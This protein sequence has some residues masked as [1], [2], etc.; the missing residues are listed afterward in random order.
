MYAL[1][2]LAETKVNR[3]NDEPLR[4]RAWHNPGENLPQLG[5]NCVYLKSIS[6]AQT[7]HRHTKHTRQQ[8]ALI[9]L[10]VGGEEY[11]GGW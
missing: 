10:M 11:M 8:F 3:I 2:A 4:A 1:Y 5:V 9:C 6:P 7:Q